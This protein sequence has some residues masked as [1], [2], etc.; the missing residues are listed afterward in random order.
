MWQRNTPRRCALLNRPVAAY[1]KYYL[2]ILIQPETKTCQNEVQATF[3]I[4]NEV[5]NT[6]R[7]RDQHAKKRWST[8]VSPASFRSWITATRRSSDLISSLPLPK[9]TSP[10]HHVIARTL[11]AR[12]SASFPNSLHFGCSAR[13][14]FPST[15][16]LGFCPLSLRS[17]CCRFD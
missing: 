3:N 10:S 6:Y 1:W 16:V 8:F 11:K 7:R 9:S 2:T 13:T 14:T 15:L 4:G 17:R 5:P 12:S